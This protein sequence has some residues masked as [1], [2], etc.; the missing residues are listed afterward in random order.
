MFVPK[1]PG[2]LGLDGTGGRAGRVDMGEG[3]PALRQSGLGIFGN[4]LDEIEGKLGNLRL[5]GAGRVV[6]LSPGN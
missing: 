2:N 1:Y 3:D 4:S 6:R 5:D